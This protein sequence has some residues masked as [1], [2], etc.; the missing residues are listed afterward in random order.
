MRGGRAHRVSLA[1]NAHQW[2]VVGLAVAADA[3]QAPVGAELCRSSRI[4][5]NLLS[6]KCYI[7]NPISFGACAYMA[8]NACSK[9]L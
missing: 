7:A 2:Q 1:G 5:G 4:G 3:S 6:H 9:V 8:V